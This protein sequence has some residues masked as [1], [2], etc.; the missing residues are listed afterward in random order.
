MCEMVT[1]GEQCSESREVT[2]MGPSASLSVAMCTYNGEL[3]LREQLSSI[4]KQT[5]IPDELVVCDDASSDD[6][7][8]ILESFRDGAPFPVG[9]YRNARRLGITR[10]F[11]QAVSL[12]KGDII[13]LCDQDDVWMPD[14]LRRL[15]QT[16]LANPE[17]GYAFSDAVV[18]DEGLHPL[19]YTTW[20]AVRFRSRERRQFERGRQL[21]V[22]VR[23]NVV[24]GPT[25]VFRS[26]LREKMLPF[27]ANWA[28]DAWMA[29]A[30]SA[31]GRGGILLN[32]PLIYYRKHSGQAVGIGSPAVRLG[33]AS[34]PR[35]EVRDQWLR[36]VE[37]ITELRSRVLLLGGQGCRAGELLNAKIAHLQARAVICGPSR[38][39]AL[40]EVVSEVIARR[41]WRFSAGLRSA[42]ADLLRAVGV[43]G[44]GRIRVIRRTWRHRKSRGGQ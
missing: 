4:T 30:A 1:G 18:V 17:A 20:Q 40:A 39:R 9:V 41:Y 6:T 19:G 34:L 15:E 31:L 11:E 5:R 26:E 44:S 13:A 23:R 16:L 14:K 2:G 43:L 7:V 8:R 38:S 29:L 21:G 33:R 24:T 3:Y 36:E 25:M 12:C 32:V 42:A 27:P 35:W 28:D 37:R 10:N 22:L